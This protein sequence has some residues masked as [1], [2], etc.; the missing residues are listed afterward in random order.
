MLVSMCKYKTQQSYFSWSY[1]WSIHKFNKEKE[2]LRLEIC[3]LMN[4]AFN[5][6]SS[7]ILWFLEI[8]FLFVKKVFIPMHL[9]YKTDIVIESL[10]RAFYFSFTSNGPEAPCTTYMSKVKHRF[11]RLQNRALR[12]KLLLKKHSEKLQCT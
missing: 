7:M 1:L 4:T 3:I 8:V 11:T 12:S 2:K 9:K 6:E 10:L 5:S